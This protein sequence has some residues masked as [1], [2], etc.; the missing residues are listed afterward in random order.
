MV[1]ASSAQEVPMTVGQQLES[2][3]ETSETE[4]EDDSYLQELSRFIQK[5]LNINTVE[6]N[7]LKELS[8]LS[9]LQVENFISYRGLLGKIIDICELQAVP[10]W[11][12]GTIRR[13]LPFITIITTIPIQEEM[14]SRFKKG[15]HSLLLRISQVLEKSKGFIRDSTG[16][17][18]LGGPQKIFFRHRYTYKNLLQYG[19][20]GEK[21]AGEQFFK[22]SQKTG[23]DFYSLH[24]F[25]RKIGIIKALAL[26]D[27]TVNM[28]QG[29][30]HW[31][32]LAFKMSAGVMNVKRQSPV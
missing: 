12:I 32:G 1:Q 31:Q 16:S 20:T 17:K 13:L 29:L 22:G 15:E 27:F 14:G 23:F 8:M 3:A 7:E 26:G 11:D 24:L 21:D 5:P 30:I 18:Y 4:M 25:M 19:F 6:K 28:G 10:L 2:I 9:E